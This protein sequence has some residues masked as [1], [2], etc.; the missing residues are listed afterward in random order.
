[1]SKKPRKSESDQGSLCCIGHILENETTS[2]WSPR[3]QKVISRSKKKY[4]EHP[5]R[6]RR[7]CGEIMT[8]VKRLLWPMELGVWKDK[9]VTEFK[10]RHCPARLPVFASFLF[11]VCS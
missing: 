3:G 6:Q 1:M 7:A 5:S 10:T 9:E 8:S 11:F 4:I 2:C